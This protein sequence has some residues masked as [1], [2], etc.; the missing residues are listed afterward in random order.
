MPQ[1]LSPQDRHEADATW[2]PSGK[3][4]AFGRVS[5][6]S[7]VGEIQIFDLTSQKPSTVPGSSGM[8]SPRWL[9]DGRWY[10]RRALGKPTSAAFR[11]DT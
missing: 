3:Q 11:L 6:G 8:F 7:D 1:E 2:S 10:S 5:Y 4:I 9:P